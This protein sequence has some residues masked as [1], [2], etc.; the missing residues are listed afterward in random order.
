MPV[1]IKRLHAGGVIL[2]F[3]SYTVTFIDNELINYWIYDGILIMQCH[4]VK[5]GCYLL[6]KCTPVTY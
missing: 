2:G 5:I 3:Q 4:S 6:E 1:W